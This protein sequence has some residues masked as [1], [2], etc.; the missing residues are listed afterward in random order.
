MLVISHQN[1]IIDGFGQR[2]SI[3]KGGPHLAV[4]FRRYIDGDDKPVFH[5]QRPQLPHKLGQ[6]RPVLRMNIFI[7]NINAIKII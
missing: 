3:Q 6:I 4:G 1:Q 7:I 5:G 2:P